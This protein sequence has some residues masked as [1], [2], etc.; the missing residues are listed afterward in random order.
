MAVLLG[1][2]QRHVPSED[3]GGRDRTQG[4]AVTAESPVPD[5]PNYQQVTMPGLVTVRADIGWSYYCL[6]C[7][8]RS[9]ASHAGPFPTDR[10]MQDAIAGH[11]AVCHKEDG[12]GR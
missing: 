2:L 10:D 6:I 12:D 8:P 9:K 5:N 4:E 1:P 11:V 3:R 7:S